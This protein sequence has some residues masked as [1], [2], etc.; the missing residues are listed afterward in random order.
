MVAVRVLVVGDCI[1]AA[2][3]VDVVVGGD[4]VVPATLVFEPCA[5]GQGVSLVLVALVRVRAEYYLFPLC[6]Y[7]PRAYM[8]PSQKV[9][10]VYHNLASLVVRHLTFVETD[11]S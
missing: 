11:R 5:L 1:V 8:L 10:L 6:P 2:A 4:R 9:H 7:P 3:A